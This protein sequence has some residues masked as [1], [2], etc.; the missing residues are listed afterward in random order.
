MRVEPFSFG[1]IRIDGI[2]YEHDV[3]IHRGKV[4]KRNKKPYKKLR[5]AFGHTH[6][7]P[8]RRSRG[9]VSAWSSPREPGR[10][11]S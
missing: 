1:S 4:R 2:T 9:D 3:V 6:C 5:D 8:R 10:C 7:P 11:R